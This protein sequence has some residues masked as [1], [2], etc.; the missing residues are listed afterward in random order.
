MGFLLEASWRP[1][2]VENGPRELQ[3]APKNGPRASQE[4][5]ISPWKPPLSRPSIFKSSKRRPRGPQGL[6]GTPPSLPG[7]PPGPLRDT[8]GRSKWTQGELQETSQRPLHPCGPRYN[9]PGHVFDRSLGKSMFS[10]SP[11]LQ[12]KFRWLLMFLHVAPS[13]EKSCDEL[14]ICQAMRRPGCPVDKACLTLRPA[15][16]SRRPPLHVD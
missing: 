5:P 6:L 4:R 9:F 14:K 11:K 16:R 10:A 3:D 7:T 13:N 2:C 15:P 8:L 12:M 1:R